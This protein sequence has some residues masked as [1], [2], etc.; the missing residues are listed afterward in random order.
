MRLDVSCSAAYLYFRSV[1]LL[2]FHRNLLPLLPSP[3]RR[4]KGHRTSSCVGVGTTPSSSPP[5]LYSNSRQQLST[6]IGGGE[7]TVGQWKR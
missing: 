1:T 5:F 3:F 4:V 7:R 6:G 2:P